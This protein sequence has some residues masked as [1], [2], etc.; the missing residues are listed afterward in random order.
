MIQEIL[1]LVFQDLGQVVGFECFSDHQDILA[2]P[3]C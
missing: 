2:V 3:C 1:T